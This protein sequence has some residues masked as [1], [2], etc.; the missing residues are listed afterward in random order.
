M[1]HR[2]TINICGKLNITLIYQGGLLIGLSIK[3]IMCQILNE[4]RCS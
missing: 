4:P 2:S 3:F 1:Y